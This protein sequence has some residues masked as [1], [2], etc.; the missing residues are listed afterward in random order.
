MHIKDIV[1]AGLLSLSLFFACQNPTNTGLQPYVETREKDSLG[2]LL[3][4][5]VFVQKDRF[6]VYL[7]I[8]HSNMAGSPTYDTTPHPRVWNYQLPEEVN[9]YAPY[10]W[11]PSVDGL[12]VWGL[13]KTDGPAIP[14]LKQMAEKYPGYYFGAIQNAHTSASYSSH[15]Y[16]G[17]PLYNEIVEAFKSTILSFF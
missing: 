6:L 16:P 9:R 10:I 7:F 15:Y 3:P 2:I 1:T 13:Y 12:H 5:G 11:R 8:G 17:G 14:F 4:N